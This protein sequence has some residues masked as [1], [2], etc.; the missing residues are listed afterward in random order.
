MYRLIRHR[1]VAL[2]PRFNIWST[3]R[4]SEGYV[5]DCEYIILISV[6]GT[7]PQRAETEEERVRSGQESQGSFGQPGEIGKYY[8][9]VHKVL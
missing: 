2:K 8:K 7:K 1:S 3:T 5:Y 6:V 9:A 4:S